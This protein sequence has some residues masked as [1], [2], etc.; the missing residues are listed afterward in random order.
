MNVLFKKAEEIGSKVFGVGGSQSQNDQPA[1]VSGVAEVELSYEQQRHKLH[2]DVS[3][4]AAAFSTQV[5]LATGV[6]PS[7]QKIVGFKV[8]WFNNR[9][10]YDRFPDCTAARS[11]QTASGQAHPTPL[12]PDADMRKL[13]IRP[14]MKLML[15][16]VKRK[17]P[18]I[19]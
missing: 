5:Y 18:S 9:K 2:L 3:A 4:T 19:L 6:I 1:L 13:G 15:F 14:S 16:Q 10:R 12:L 11:F 8:F 17:I 7:R